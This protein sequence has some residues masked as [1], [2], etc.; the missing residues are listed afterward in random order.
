MW[1]RLLERSMDSA[2]ASVTNA[3]VLLSHL[4]FGTSI[5]LPGKLYSWCR[6]LGRSQAAALAV[7]LLCSHGHHSQGCGNATLF[8]EVRT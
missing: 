7:N 2:E 8:T 1:T 3:S 5:R 4:L 6:V